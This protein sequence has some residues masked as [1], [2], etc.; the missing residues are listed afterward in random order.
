METLKEKQKHSLSFFTS[1]YR[2][3][4]ASATPH[5]SSKLLK[6]S[7]FLFEAIDDVTDEFS[8]QSKG[9]I[10]VGDKSGDF[11]QSASSLHF[12]NLSSCIRL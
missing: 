3:R 2:G 9:F 12:S 5:F 1:L 4:F 11:K 7:R 8:E 10:W 6:F